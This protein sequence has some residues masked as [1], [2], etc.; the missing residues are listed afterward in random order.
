MKVVEVYADVACPF[1]HAGLRRFVAYRNGRAKAEPVLRVRAWPLELVNGEPLNGP[2]LTPKVAALRAHAAPDLFGGFDECSFPAT[3]LPALAAEASAYR[4]GLEVGEQFSLA[5]RHALFEDGLDVS[6]ADVLA[7]IRNAYG[8]P[9]PT[10][11]DRASVRDDFEEGKQREVSGSP[12]FFTSQGN[13]FCPSLDI[14]HDRDGY[15]VRFD[16]AGF[17]KFVA[18]VFD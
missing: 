9:E 12:H 10:E 7:A 6:D 17:E 16:A 4:V 5:L 15:Q 8:V 1:T 11:A 14:A 13:F 18:A 2:S 3:T